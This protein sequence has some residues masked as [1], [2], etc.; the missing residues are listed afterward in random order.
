MALPLS[1]RIGINS[2]N[3]FGNEKCYDFMFKICIFYLC[4]F[5][6][7]WKHLLSDMPFLDISFCICDYVWICLNLP[8][9][10][11]HYLTV[12]FL[13]RLFS[14]G[15]VHFDHF[16]FRLFKFILWSFDLSILAMSTLK[17]KN[18]SFYSFHSMK[19]TKTL[20]EF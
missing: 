12:S 3:F 11:E 20:V 17:K 16:Y 6:I 15:L 14:F 9:L 7:L 10:E 18:W 2:T 4:L 8:L 1:Q 5:L 19:L 13:S